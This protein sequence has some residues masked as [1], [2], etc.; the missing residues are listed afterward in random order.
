MLVA[1]SSWGAKAIIAFVSF[2]NIRLISEAL[3]LEGFAFYYLLIGLIPI[4]TL[5]DIGLGQ[6]LQNYVSEARAKCENYDDIISATFVMAL[7]FATGAFI[8]TLICGYFLAPRFLQQFQSVSQHEKYANFYCL[9]IIAISTSFA[10]FVYKLWYAEQRG[11]LPNLLQSLAA[12]FSFGLI[13]TLVMYWKTE[14]V[15]WY[16][17]LGN[18][19]QAVF[20]M[21]AYLPRVVRCWRRHSVSFSSLTYRPLLRRAIGFWSFNAVAVGVLHVDYIV[22]SQFVSPPDIV[23]YTIASRVINIGILL[24]TGILLAVWPIS[25][26]LNAKQKYNEIVSLSRKLSK[27]ILGFTLAFTIF[28]LLTRDV[29]VG[30][31]L[32]D[33]NVILPFW[34]VLLLGISMLVRAWTDINAVLLQSMNETKPLLIWASMQ[35]ILSISLQIILA[36][37]LGIYGIVIGIAA[38]FLL[39]VGWA[40]PVKLTSLLRQTS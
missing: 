5:S 38:S 22:L 2:F 29:L 15:L 1:A 35:A 31:L 20:P 3:G 30:I 12:I 25:A 26:E 40:L 10:S 27:Y 39:T 13:Y 9:A 21:A 7:I 32:P 37:L 16:I 6:S 24:Y 23:I 33:Q 4:F 17:I 18:L 8:F 34:F 19:P 11:Y 28:L 14:N 36:P